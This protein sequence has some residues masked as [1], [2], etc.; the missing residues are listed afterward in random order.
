MKTLT[1]IANNKRAKWFLDSLDYVTYKNNGEE[2]R[3]EILQKNIED[4]HI[5]VLIY[6]PSEVEGT[7]SD[8][9]VVDKEGDIVIAPERIYNQEE[10]DYPRGLY[11]SFEY[12]FEEEVINLNKEK[13]E[14]VL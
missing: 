6:F 13:E 7:I 12:I 14:E 8:V 5:E 11:I 4:N 1:P 9:K 10:S 2:K 3:S